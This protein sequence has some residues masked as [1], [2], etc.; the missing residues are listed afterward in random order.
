MPT[1]C[2]GAPLPNNEEGSIT[3]KSMVHYVKS[4]VTAVLL[5]VSVAIPEPGS[6][7]IMRRTLFCLALGLASVGSVWVQCGAID[8]AV[9]SGLLSGDTVIVGEEVC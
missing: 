1:R 7:T 5:G 4:A 9:V 2:Y 6:R 3:I 8:P